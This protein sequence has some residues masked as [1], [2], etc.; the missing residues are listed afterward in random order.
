MPVDAPDV[1]IDRTTPVFVALSGGVDS[2]V[3]AHLLRKQYGNLTGISH[4]HWPES[5]CCSTACLDR[6]A[7]QCATLGIPYVAVDCIVEFAQQ[8]VDDFVA[9]YERGI[10]PNPCVLCNETIRFGLMVD[11][12]FR[13]SDDSPPADY[14]IATG[15]Y[16]RVEE[17]NGR[18]HL[19]R[20][21]DAARD[22]S[23]MLYRLSQEELSHCRFPLGDLLKTEVRTLAQKWNLQAAKVADS[24]D[25][26]FVADRYQDFIAQYSDNVQ[27]PGP[28]VDAEGHPMGEHQGIAYYT[29]GQ[30]SGLGLHGGPWYVL[31]TDAAT[32]TIT[33]GRRDDLFETAFE[34]QQLR[35]VYPEVDEM[36]VDLQSRYRGVEQACRFTRAGDDVLRVELEAPSADITPGQ[37]AVFY[38][39]DDVVGGGII[40]RIGS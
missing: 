24:Q 12:H 5:R 39:G 17:R 8:I 31:R 21:R 22:Q 14:K 29:R 32:N 10:T 1:L 25:V 6:C 40:T 16:A 3:A 23:Y 30:R 15:H 27:V 36:V 9:G 28:F 18:F 19:M 11:K 4:R 35:W 20:G 38:L 34:V 13:D 37:S 2:A 26:C 33:L 7:E